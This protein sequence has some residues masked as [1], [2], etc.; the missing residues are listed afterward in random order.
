MMRGEVCLIN[1]DPTIG[2]EIQKTRPAVI[3]S[4]DGIGVLP[5]KVIVPVTEW[6]ER[7]R[8]APWLVR[9]E[10]SSD[11]GLDKVSAADA[12]Q[13]RSVAR[14]RF[15]RRLGVLTDPQM[16]EIAQALATVLAI[17]P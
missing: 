1:L 11:N 4:D 16:A 3:V 9:I 17:E 5:L 8:I 13:V 7:F 6:K 10:P 12:F 2:P 14:Q 15:V